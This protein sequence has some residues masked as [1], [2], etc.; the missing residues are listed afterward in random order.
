MK[1]AGGMLPALPI[2]AAVALAIA[3]GVLLPAAW[4][5]W[6]EPLASDRVALGPLL[7]CQTTL[8][9]LL[10]WLVIHR[11]HQRP[12]RALKAQASRLAAPASGRAAA[13]PRHPPGDELR[14]LGRHLDLAQGRIA[15]LLGQLGASNTEL[16]RM[17]MYDQ[18]TGLPNRRLFSELFDHALARARRGRQ[19]MALLFID[20]DRFKHINDT[21]GHPAGD[22]LLLCISQR[23]RET[24]RES[25]I[26]GRL[27]GD[28]FVALLPQA[29]TFESIAHTALRLIQAVEVPVPIDHTGQTVRVSATIGVS[30]FP[31]D[32]VDFDEL[33]LRADQAMYRAKALGRGRFALY[34][35]GQT[36]GMPSVTRGDDELRQALKRGE[37]MMHYQPVVDTQGGKV[38][39]CEA[40]MR[41]QHPR[42]GLLGPARFIRRAE[43]CGML[44]ALALLAADAACEQNARWKR[45]GHQPGRISIN[46][47]DAQFRHPAWHEVLVAALKRHGTE[48]GELEVELTEATL[49]ADP[50]STQARVDMLHDLG[51]AVAIDDFGT[52]LISLSR[53][54][55]LKPAR[56]KLDSSFVQRL[57]DDDSARGLVD[58]VVRLSRSLGFQ[59]VG[60]G[61][62]TEAQRD[63]LHRLGCTQQQGHL[64]GEPQPALDE[65]PW[66]LPTW[67]ARPSG[68]AAG[69]P[70]TAL[71]AYRE[72]PLQASSRRPRAH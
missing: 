10:L 56:V 40:L 13:P 68:R 58:G 52:G 55:A 50:E 44:Q 30:R 34:R 41:W 53:L 8:A 65:P 71:R 48:R 21:H 16:H 51:V 60:E 66:P 39:A 22:A 2:R 72:M 9:V 59:V 27:S 35:D 24:A 61:V 63:T 69:L 38:V 32:G 26:I 42:D 23:L 4:L 5:L 33:L 18:L 6:P 45:A 14:E 43:D 47:S 1:R 15:E 7:A 57:P 29:I 67:S 25:D 37:L 36:P 11:Y 31:R 46:V 28:E 64:F 17:A 3:A 54:A 19:P 62:E 20:L 12:I 49:M 70:A